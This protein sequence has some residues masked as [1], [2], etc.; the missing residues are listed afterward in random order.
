LIAVSSATGITSSTSSLLLDRCF[1]G[2]RDHVVDVE[3][4]A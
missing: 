2:D 4:V 3:P 1:V